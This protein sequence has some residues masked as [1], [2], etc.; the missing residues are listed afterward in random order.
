MSTRRHV[1][2][3]TR[4]R[5]LWDRHRLAGST[6]GGITDLVDDLVALHA[7]DAATVYLSVVAR[8]PSTTVAEMA[9]TLYDSRALVRMMGMRRTVFVVSGAAA[10]VVQHSSAD[11]VAVR[12]RRALV[13][14]LEPVVAGADAWLAAL[15]DAVVERLTTGGDATATALARDEPRLTT[16][17]GDPDGRYGA[18]AIT[19]RVLT[20]L[21]TQGRI[22]RGRPGGGWTGTRYTWSA[23]SRWFPDGL[24]RLD[25]PT[26]RVALLHRYLDRFGPVTVTDAAWWTGWSLTDTRRALAALAPEEVDLDGGGTGL[27]LPGA[28]PVPDPPTG[29]PAVALLPALDPTPMGWK[30]RDWYL[31]PDL[32]APLFDRSGNIGPTVWCDGL[33]VGGWGQRADGTVTHRLLSDVPPDAVT[34]IDAQADR[35]TRWLDGVRVTPKFRTPLERELST[36]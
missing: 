1:D 16:R 3:Q 8:R 11:A 23:A 7:T 19:S 24:P 2:T 21:G 32:R 31:P 17:I 28:D 30:D 4:R 6:S 5:L 25:A 34:A 20:V 35:L 26:A 18:V 13:A 33:I 9:E 14:E 22:V 10:P 12:I 36:G 27:V 15:E 29:A